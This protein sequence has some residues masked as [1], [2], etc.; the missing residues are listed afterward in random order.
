MAVTKTKFMNYMRCPRYVALDKV[1]KDKLDA[2]VSFDEY[3]QE[4]QDNMIGEL[5]NK[6]YEENE[7]EEETDLIDTVN[8]Q[9]EIMMPYYNEV[10]ILAGKYVNKKLGGETKYSKDNFHQT[11]FST[12]INGIRYLCYLDIYNERENSFDVIEV[13]ATTTNTF[14]ELAY[15]Y[16]KEETSIF[17]KDNNGIYVLKEE[18]GHIFADDKEEK[19]YKAQRTK[20]SKRYEKSGRYVYD[21]AVQRYII[22]KELK[23][24]IPSDV[25]YY[26]AILNS[27]YIYDGVSDYEINND[28]EEIISL[29]DLTK[30]TKEMQDIID[31]DRKKI[32][33][34]FLNSD[35]NPYV[36][37]PYCEHKKSVACKFCSVCFAG[38]PEKNSIFSYIDG[39]HG[40]KD[41]SNNKY[42]R[43]DLLNDGLVHMLD[44]PSDYLNRE[45]N[46]I[47]RDCVEQQEEY[48]NLNKIKDGLNCI[49]YPIYH[50]DFESFPCPIPRLKG[51]KPYTQSVFQFSIHIEHSPGK[52]DKEKD[53]Y[54]FLAPNLCDHREELIKHM[55]EVISDDKGTV[56]VYNEAF[57]K[58]RLKEMAVLYPEYKQKLEKIRSNVFDL[59]HILRSN[60]KLFQELGYSEEEAKLFNYYHP[61]LNGSFSIKKVLP[62]FSDLSYD[63]MEV[64]N[65]M[66]AMTTYATFDKEKN[67]KKY[68]AMIDYCKQD[69]WAMVEILDKLRKKCE[70]KL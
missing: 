66:D 53:H 36:L 34:Y 51:E 5:L 65:G 32:E 40:F 18:L 43:F 67:E 33:E 55:C 54:G 61:D 70:E 25:K 29:I 28:G 35:A 24:E 58:P 49:T 14:L 62:I 60:N 3:R 20:L 1:H 21:L 22:E 37:G 19:S 17:E 64:G 63:N 52:C 9:L 50:L 13:K 48:T 41:E 30:I 46:K 16:N 57:E 59:M 45:K 39:H 15:K 23:E 27:N 8:E 7:H 56:L 38:V 69:T 11:S 12:N 10:E 2:D 31:I 42:E 6:M 4:E 47:Q 26:L 68:Q 44:I